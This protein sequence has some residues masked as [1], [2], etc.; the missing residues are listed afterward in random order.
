MG[1]STCSGRSNHLAYS[2]EK[3]A[4]FTSIPV[5][6]SF[7]FPLYLSTPERSPPKAELPAGLQG[8]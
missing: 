2:E 8:Q 7:V 1:S 3:T 6:I 5:N 4:R